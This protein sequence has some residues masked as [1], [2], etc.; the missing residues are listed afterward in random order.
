M[1]E[2]V[3][4]DSFMNGSPAVPFSLERRMTILARRLPEIVKKVDSLALALDALRKDPS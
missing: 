2:D 4:P 3:P 1:P